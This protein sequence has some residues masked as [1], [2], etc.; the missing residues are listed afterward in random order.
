M[1]E[2]GPTPDQELMGIKFCPGWDCHCQQHSRD[3]GV[4]AG[5]QDG[6]SKERSDSCGVVPYWTGACG[7]EPPACTDC[8][9]AYLPRAGAARSD[10]GL[11]P[12]T[13]VT[14]LNSEVRV[15]AKRLHLSVPEVLHNMIRRR[16]LIAAL[17]AMILSLGAIAF[18]DTICPNP[19]CPNP[20]ECPGAISGQCPYDGQCPHDGQGPQDGSGQG[21]GPHGQGPQDGSGGQNR[22]ERNCN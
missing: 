8:A 13:D 11:Q 15:M 18:A 19:N 6:V 20:E 10:V 21:Q 7:A 1:V 3:R 9:I 2:H 17:M 5:L 16:F 14:P 12:V 22:H 4:H